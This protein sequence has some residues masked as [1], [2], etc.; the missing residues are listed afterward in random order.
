MG[1]QQGYWPALSSHGGLYFI[2]G[3]RV[4]TLDWGWPILDGDWHLCPKKHHGITRVRGTGFATDS[5]RK[6]ACKLDTCDCGAYIK[7][8][9]SVVATD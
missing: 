2:A 9:S 7:S 8:S 1:R 5:G 3:T 4:S 6:Y